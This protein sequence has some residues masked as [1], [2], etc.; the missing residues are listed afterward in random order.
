MQLAIANVLTP[1]GNVVVVALAVFT[2]LLGINYVYSL[3]ATKLPPG[4]RAGWFGSVN[5]PTCYQWLTYAK[6]RDLYGELDNGSY[7]SDVVLI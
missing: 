7:Y 3:R 5:V 2:A 6:W 4:P 1:L